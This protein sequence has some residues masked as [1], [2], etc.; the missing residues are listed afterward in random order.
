MRVWRKEPAGWV[1]QTDWRELLINFMVA[2]EIEEGGV[3]G[4]M[5]PFITYLTD[6]EIALLEPLQAEV[7]RRIDYYY[8]N[9]YERMTSA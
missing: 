1:E 8:A 9:D 6:E 2:A 3:V 4:P 5:L 7:L